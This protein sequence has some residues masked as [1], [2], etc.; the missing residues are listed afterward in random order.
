MGVVAIDNVRGHVLMQQARHDLDAKEASYEA[1][2]DD[3]SGGLVGPTVF[4]EIGFGFRKHAVQ[5]GEHLNVLA[6]IRSD[7]LGRWYNVSSP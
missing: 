7:G 5:R 6:A 4:L 1:C 3:E 2:H